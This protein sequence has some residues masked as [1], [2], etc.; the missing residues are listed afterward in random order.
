[1]TEGRAAQSFYLPSSTSLKIYVASR[2]ERQ[3]ELRG[4]A[5]ELRAAGHTVTSRWLLEETDEVGN[6]PGVWQHNPAL[7]TFA[8]IDL[9]DINAADVFMVFTHEGLSRGG[10][11]V[12][13]GYALAFGKRLVVI[14]P[15]ATLF[16]FLP[17]VNHFDTWEEAREFVGELSK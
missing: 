4:Y 9:E 14:G 10:M 16:H 8:Q 11:H 15:Q 6:K 13:F 7:R 2:F 3:T 17:N 12:E 5:K 1:M